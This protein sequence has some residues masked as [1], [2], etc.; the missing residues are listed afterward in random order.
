M[1][2]VAIPNS[3]TA[4]LDFTE[5]DLILKSLAD[6]TMAELLERLSTSP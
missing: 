5:A 1:L 6:V 3:I 2:C 4:R